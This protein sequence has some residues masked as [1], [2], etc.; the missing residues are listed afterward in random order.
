MS[1]P[2]TLSKWLR[3]ARNWLFFHRREC[4][5][6]FAAVVIAV[7]S[8]R[9]A[10]AHESIWFSQT[11][12]TTTENPKGAERRNLCSTKPIGWSRRSIRM[13][14]R[15][16]TLTTHTRPI[17][18]ARRDDWSIPLQPIPAE[19]GDRRYCERSARSFRTRLLTDWREHRC[20]A[21]MHY[22]DFAGSP[23]LA[24][25]SVSSARPQPPSATSST[26]TIE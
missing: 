12:N 1:V 13:A 19:N 21:S 24:R 16:R 6:F 2:P 20:F 14:H 15:R 22:L 25:V 9:Y 18:T 26:R 23:I 17:S 10:Y 11:T 8:R 5:D 4:G 7:W 3:P